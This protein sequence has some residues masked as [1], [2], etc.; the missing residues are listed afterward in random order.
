MLN[1]NLFA[2]DPISF[3][4]LRTSLPGELLTFSS[5]SSTCL[6]ELSSQWTITLK[7]RSFLHHLLPLTWFQV[8][9]PS[10]AL[11]QCPAT[12]SEFCQSPPWRASSNNFHVQMVQGCL[13]L[14]SFVC[15]I[16]SYKTLNALIRVIQKKTEPVQL[17][18][19]ICE[20]IS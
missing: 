19:D 12:N 4:A 9:L 18:R 10:A 13:K 2:W 15:D 1:S 20:K 8:L 11:M 5:H 16:P 3:Q 7:Y 14:S 6:L 17:S